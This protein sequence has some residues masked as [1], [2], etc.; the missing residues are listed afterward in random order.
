MENNPFLLARIVEKTDDDG[1][2]VKCYVVE[3]S[4]A[5]PWQLE[6]IC[7]DGKYI[8]IKERGGVLRVKLCRLASELHLSDPVLVRDV[9][10]DYGEAEVLDVI[11]RE[12]GRELRIIGEAWSE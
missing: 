6:G 9:G 12:L 5:A 3:T 11:E 7:E 2:V 10:S 1:S 8:Y 4:P